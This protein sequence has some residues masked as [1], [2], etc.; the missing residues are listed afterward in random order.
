MTL[1]V[2]QVTSNVIEMTFNAIRIMR[3]CIQMTLMDLFK[4][5]SN[6]HEYYSGALECY[7]D[8]VLNATQ[9]TLEYYSNDL[10][11]Y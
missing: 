4:S 8:M 6:D 1:S 3:F 7:S 5:Y 2:I 9:M 10:E 11:C